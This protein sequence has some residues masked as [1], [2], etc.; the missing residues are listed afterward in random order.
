MPVRPGGRPCH[1]GSRG[2][3]ETEVG[4]DAVLRAIGIDGDGGPQVIDRIV[5]AAEA[6]RF[7]ARS[8]AS[9]S[10]GRW[11]EHLGPVSA[12]WHV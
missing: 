3:W 8:T 11:L 12:G 1:C 7:R 2:C 10:I 5:A 9:G 4:E 6:G